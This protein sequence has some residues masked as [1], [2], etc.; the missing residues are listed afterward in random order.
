[1]GSNGLVTAGTGLTL[2]GVTAGTGNS[3]RVSG[4]FV[5]FTPSTPAASDP[6][7]FTYTVSDGSSTATATVTVSTVDATPFTLDLLRVVTPAAYNGSST[8]VTVE[9]A[10]VPNQ[11]Y[12]IEYST[13]LDI[14]SAPQAVET[15]STG[16]FEA[17]FTKDGNQLPAW[18]SLFFRAS[19]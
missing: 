16:T 14:W 2:T 8:S 10:G 15:G 4:A 5:F 19:R 9:F 11:T 7:T 13:G 3:V 17:T 18:N 6:T 1:V 12:Q